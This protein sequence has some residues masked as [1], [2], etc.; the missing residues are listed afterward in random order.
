[1]TPLAAGLLTFTACVFPTIEL[2]TQDSKRADSSATVTIEA[3]AVVFRWRSPTKL[4]LA[5]IENSDVAN[6]R[7]QLPEKTKRPA[8]VILS[9]RSVLKPKSGELQKP[10]L[11]IEESID[12]GM[13][14][15]GYLRNRRSVR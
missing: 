6:S 3:K 9:W 11:R 1:M 4:M 13:L 12:A 15:D 8:S 7:A 2:P 14:L 5:P 10:S